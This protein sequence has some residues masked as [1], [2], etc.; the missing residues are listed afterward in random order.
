MKSYFCRTLDRPKPRQEEKGWSGKLSPSPG[1]T[2][3]TSELPN[4]GV[5]PCYLLGLQNLAP[6]MSQGWGVPLS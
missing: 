1:L 5:P 6:F 4:A 3:H 2:E